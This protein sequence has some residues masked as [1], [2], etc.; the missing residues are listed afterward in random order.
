V[1]FAG[2]AAIL[3]LAALELAGCA[4]R[5]WLRS[6]WPD[7]FEEDFPDDPRIP[8]LEPCGPGCW[9]FAEAVVDSFHPRRWQTPPP[10]GTFRIVALGDSTVLG[11]F[12]GML[13][14]GLRVPGQSVEVLNFGL[15]GAAS[16]HTLQVAREALEQAPDLVLVY[17]GHNEIMEARDD[18]SSSLSLAAR[19]RR[20]TLR[21]S[22]LAT[23]V[24]APLAAIAELADSEDEDPSVGAGPLGD[25]EWRRVGAAYQRNLEQIC[26]LAE[27]AG[28]PLF[29]VEPVSS[30]QHSQDLQLRGEAVGAEELQ[31]RGL[32]LLAAGERPE[33]LAL[34]SE[35]REGEWLPDRAHRGHR[36]RVAQAA[37][38]CGATLVAA[39]PAFEA[40]PRLLDPGD[41]LFGDPVHPSSHGALLLAGLIAEAIAPSLPSG[42]RFQAPDPGSWPTAPPHGWMPMLE[43]GRQ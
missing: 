14:A 21:S 41:P 25:E 12:P 2:V 35:A 10:A 20:A 17:V 1:C 7:V 9:T 18:P 22:G 24:R 38:R 39:H 33:A 40:A 5:P 11:P 19:R 31:A 43:G 13:E 23:L 32:E 3:G 16:T 8:V 42:S 15:G 36:E 34:L 6:A 4:L 37:A 28:A 30:L 29:M 26:A 27:G